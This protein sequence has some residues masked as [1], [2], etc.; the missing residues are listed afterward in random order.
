MASITITPLQADLP[1]GARISGVTYE[2]LA[3]EAIRKQINDTFLARGMIVFENVES[4][5]EMQVAISTEGTVS[6]CKIIKSSGSERLDNAA[7][8]YVKGHWRWKPP[9][10]EGKPVTANTDVSVVWN[11][12]DA[13]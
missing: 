1:F 9:T 5:G 8:E 4:T 2:A 13:Q 7:C 3:D 6:E 11:L 10:S 12:K